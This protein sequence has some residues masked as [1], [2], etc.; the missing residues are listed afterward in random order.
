M[1]NKKSTR[2]LD[3]YD[4]YKAKIYNYCWYRVNF[5]RDTAEDLTSEIFIKA[6][7][8]FESF[9]PEG[10]FQAW[11]YAIAHNHLVNHY[12]KSGREVPLDDFEFAVDN[13]TAKVHTSL[14]T[15]KVLAEIAKLD[16]YSRDVLLMKYVDE[17]DSQEIAQALGKKDG[18]VR[19]QISRALA[20]LKEK[21]AQ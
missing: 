17:L 20:V 11:I 16:G 5:D 9:D 14:E 6:F 19:T 4:K 3:H 18:A 8:N 1:M 15:E 2:F 7:S 10:S 21:L 13:L 12:R